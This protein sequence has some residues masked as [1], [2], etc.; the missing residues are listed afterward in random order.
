MIFLVLD[1]MDDVELRWYIWPH[2]TFSGNTICRMYSHPFHRVEIYDI[3]SYV[4]YKYTFRTNQNIA[5]Y[6]IHGE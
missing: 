3:D 6:F 4:N 2:R 5:N 1:T